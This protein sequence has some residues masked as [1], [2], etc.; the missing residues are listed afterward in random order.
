MRHIV[1]MNGRGE[2][3]GRV[4]DSTM[5]RACAAGALT[6][7][8]L[9]VL[10]AAPV[11][12]AGVPALSEISEIAIHTSSGTWAFTNT[13]DETIRHLGG[14]FVRSDAAVLRDA[15]VQRLLDAL[16]RPDTSTIP[17][18][19]MG[20]DRAYLLA[21]LD[22]AEAYLGDAISIPGARATFDA[23]FLDAAA[24][25]QWFVQ[26][27]FPVW[28]WEKKPPPDDKKPRWIFRTSSPRFDRRVEV[29]VTAARGSVTITASSNLP[30]ML[31]VTIDDGGKERKS[32]DPAIP[33]ALAAL[34]SDSAMLGGRL[35]SANAYIQWADV[36]A[37]SK[38]VSTAIQRDAVDADGAARIAKAAGLSIEYIVLKDPQKWPDIE[39]SL[40]D[41]N[42]V[43]F[44]GSVN[45]A[46]GWSGWAGDP[47]LPT[48]KYT[49]GGV[50]SSPA[51]LEV[52]LRPVAE[53]FH[54]ARL[55]TW[56]TTALAATPRA[57]ADLQSADRQTIDG[58]VSALRT[59]GK[60]R[61]AQLLE[62]NERHATLLTVRD[63]AATGVTKWLLL[64]NGETILLDFDEGA[65]FAFG[66]K[67]YRSLPRA[68]KNA[69]FAA[70]GVLVAPDGKVDR[71]PPAEPIIV[72]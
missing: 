68:A 21:N 52:L 25:Q 8:A 4:A 39:D 28:A 15:N 19:R 11:R 1:D 27:S 32:M 70:V 46:A 37:N 59:L 34:M 41:P 44:A 12:A 10:G 7:L 30:F 26:S 53:A 55:A 36:V 38:A 31:P 71:T 16:A 65:R 20:F 54:A 42:V 33:R 13:H 40:Y 58:Y 60:T 63:G 6:L 69:Q 62:R 47:A 51:Y 49:M 56:L 14:A 9:V 24:M 43:P 50:R 72:L 66:T 64:A 23:M 18:A 48:V 67:W 45:S 17:A 57:S 35:S 3:R 29:K 22:E 2:R 5:I 61:A